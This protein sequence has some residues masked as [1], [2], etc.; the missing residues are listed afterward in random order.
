MRLIVLFGCLTT[1]FLSPQ[2]MASDFEEA[3][4][5]VPDSAH[6]AS[7]R[8]AETQRDFARAKAAMAAAVL[9]HAEC[10]STALKGDADAAQIAKG[11]LSTRSAV[12]A[13][14][15]TEFAGMEISVLEQ[16]IATTSASAN[17]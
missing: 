17:K 7:M 8:T 10:V 9:A 11:C 6:H 12:A 16:R 5:D 3:K 4:Q 14:L 15:P 1:L 13:L 2:V